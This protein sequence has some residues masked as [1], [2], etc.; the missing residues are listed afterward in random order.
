M[1]KTI[2]HCD[3]NA[4]YV[5]CELIDKT[6]LKNKPVCVAGSKDERK[7]IILSKN[8]IAKKMGVKTAETIY[9]S[10][11]KCPDLIV[12]QA[13]HFKYQDYC[14][15]VRK[16]FSNYSDIIT[17]F[18]I[19][20]AWIDIT[21][22]INYFNG[23]EN[24]VKKLMNEI[25]ETLG[26]T[27]SVGISDNKF[28]AKLASDMAG[29]DSY[30]FINNYEEIKD[31]PVYKLLMIGKKTYEKLLVLNIKTIADLANLNDEILDKHFGKNGLKLKNI[32]LGKDVEINSFN[33][34]KE[35]IK[36]I[37]HSFTLNKDIINLEEISYHFEKLTDMVHLRLLKQKLYFKTISIHIKDKNFNTYSYQKT[38]NYNTNFRKIIIN[39]CLELFNKHPLTTKI[40]LLG[41]S[42]SHLSLNKESENYQLFNLEEFETDL[43]EQKI[44][45]SIYKI[46]EK[47]GYDA[48]KNIKLIKKD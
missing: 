40:R 39:T 1:K 27:V 8:A 32:A 45:N 38:L 11:K 2:I 46:R 3:L 29:D 42:L 13:N 12:L 30:H 19:D 34:D 43:K 7:G 44:Q 28:Y 21:A 35:I 37:G 41:I 16:I 15:K 48:I 22:S 14:L 4:F 23:I 20:E 31:L 5:S 47:Y 25:K 6:W 26:L 24:L 18:G 10:L 36:S 33:Q 9:Q 17:P